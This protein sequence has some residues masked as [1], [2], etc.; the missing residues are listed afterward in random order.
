M[1]ESV[2]VR[3]KA[4]DSD[5]FRALTGPYRRQ[6]QMHCYRILGSS[7]D[8]EDILQETLLSAWLALDRF[9]GRSLKAWL[10]RIATNRCLNYLRDADRRPKSAGTTEAGELFASAT[11]SDEPRWIE[12]YPDALIDDIV[13]GPEARYDSREA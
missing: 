7:Q 2:L 13:Q 4:G 9:D 11:R 6:L 1:T 10:Y 8:A 12:P 3:A 5:A